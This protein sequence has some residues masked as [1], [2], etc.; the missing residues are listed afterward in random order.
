MDSLIRD[1][2]YQGY[3]KTDRIID[4]FSKIRRVDFVP[5]ELESASQANIPLPIGQGQTI[6]Q[7]LTVAFMMEKLGPLPGDKVLDVGSGSGWTTALLAHIVGKKG[8]VIGMERIKDLCH[9]GMNN[10]SKYNLIEGG[11]VKIICTDGT[12]GYVNEAPYQRILVSASAKEIPREMKKQLAVGGRLV[13]PV[14]NSIWTV[15]KISEKDFREEE[16]P[17]FAFVPLIGEEK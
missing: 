12:K 5:E 16:Y 8:K 1:L 17:G 4:A 7:P 14:K 10:V 13:I 3:L 15:E 11:R 6:S 9:F 2:V